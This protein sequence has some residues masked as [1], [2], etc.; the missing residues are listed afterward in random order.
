MFQ[1]PDAGYTA[2]LKEDF[3]NRFRNVSRL[4]DCVGCD[5]C[6]LWGKLQTVGYGTALKVL[7]EYDENLNGE[8]PPLRR[9]ELVALVNTL[10]RVSSSITS[11]NMMRAMVVAEEAAG[12]AAGKVA[13]NTPPADHH[14]APPPPTPKIEVEVEEEDDD[15]FDA[16]PHPSSRPNDDN[17]TLWAEITA[18]CTLIWKA[19]LYVLKSWFQLPGTLF[20]VGVVEV[21]RLWSFWLGLPVTERS[22]EFKYPSMDE[23]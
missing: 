13:E 12:A 3:R 21:S 8:N 22:W 4:M 10:D 17:T 16:F 7:F 2:E 15:D 9:T 1:D 23:L 11:L 20:K 5:K 19:Y 14:A 6:R 18:E